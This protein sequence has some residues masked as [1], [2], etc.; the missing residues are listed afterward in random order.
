MVSVREEYGE[1]IERYPSTSLEGDY[2]RWNAATAA[3]V[4]RA[5]GPGWKLTDEVIARGLAEVRWTGRWQRGR[6]GAT[7]VVFDS[8]HNPEGA[9][10]LEQS[11]SRLVSET[12]RSPVVITG[13]LGHARARALLETVCRHAREVHLVVP[14][15]ARAC[16]FEE[17]E[18]LIPPSFTGLVA[19]ATLDALFPAPDRCTVGEPG[20]VV[21][22]TGSIYLL[23]EVLSRVHPELGANEGRLQDF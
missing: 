19:R 8:S 17:L 18:S 16:G 23:G 4:A 21:V 7:E 2:Q 13:A 3:L 11:L 6:I 12:G 22:V 20:D 5:L 1:D 15:Q 14:N 9:D 10:V